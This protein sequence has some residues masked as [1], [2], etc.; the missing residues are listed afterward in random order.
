MA[1]PPK[2]AVVKLVVVLKDDHELEA[3]SGREFVLATEVIST[4]NWRSNPE[5]PW[6]LYGLNQAVRKVVQK[7][8]DSQEAWG[9]DSLRD[10]LEEKEG[11]GE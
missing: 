7:F 11:D 3:G 1:L 6:H 9:E 2:L 4:V 5:K 8:T 10:L